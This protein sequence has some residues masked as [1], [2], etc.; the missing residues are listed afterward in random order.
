MVR[1]SG[2]KAPTPHQGHLPVV[3]AKIPPRIRPYNP[4]PV[5]LLATGRLSIREPLQFQGVTDIAAWESWVGIG[6]APF[7]FNFNCLE[8]GAMLKSHP[9]METIPRTAGPSKEFSRIPVIMPARVEFLPASE[10]GVY[11]GLPAVLLD[12]GCGGG[13]VRVRW[14]L[15]P[16]TRVFISL[17]VGT[18]GLRLPAEIVWGARASGLGNEPAMYGVRWVDLLSV[19]AVQTVLLGHELTR[20]VEMAHAPRV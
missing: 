14:D 7:A 20:L 1:G 4:L 2:L 3:S 11:A 17:S 5:I 10:G 15:A 9:Q 13:K 12:I 16:G 18:P 19:G 6:I 8:G